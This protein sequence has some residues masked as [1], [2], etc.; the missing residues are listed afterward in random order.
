MG[1][2]RNEVRKALLDRASL[3]NTV[4][5]NNTLIAK[6]VALLR[7]KPRLQDDSDASPE[8]WQVYKLVAQESL[9]HAAIHAIADRQ[10]S[11]K[12]YAFINAGLIDHT[13]NVCRMRPVQQPGKSVVQLEIAS[14]VVLG[15][16]CSVVSRAVWQVFNGDNTLPS[17]LSAQVVRRLSIKLGRS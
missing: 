8:A 16:P 14:Q 4:D 15:A 7:K 9:R 17:S 6:M 13:R 1:K 12:D 11:R 3:Q 2:Q 5:A 10:Y